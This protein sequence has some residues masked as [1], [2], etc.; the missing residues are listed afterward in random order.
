MRLRRLGRR[1]DRWVDD[2]NRDRSPRRVRGA[3]AEDLEAL[4]AAIELRSAAPGA[5]LPDPHFV[6]G[7]HRRL[8]QETQG[9]ALP[10]ARGERLGEPG[11]GDR[12]LVPDGASWVDVAAVADLP[13]GTARRFSTA[14]FEGV[15]VNR[16]GNVEALSAACTHLGCIL[17]VNAADRRLECPCHRAAFGFDGSLLYKVLPQQLPPLPRMMAR[18]REGRIEVFTA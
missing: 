13:D 2:L 18:V 12:N 16:G 9:E 5:G 1:V 10:R 14:A 17:R 11:A 6:E 3:A 8:A 15:L 4:A 7:L